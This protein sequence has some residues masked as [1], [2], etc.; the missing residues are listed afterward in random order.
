MIF[1]SN[2]SSTEKYHNTIYYDTLEKQVYNYIISCG[3]IPE[4]DVKVVS[5]DK[6]LFIKLNH[7]A[8][9]FGKKNSLE[10]PFSYHEYDSGFPCYSHKGYDKFKITFLPN[11]DM[12]KK[13]DAILKKI[14]H[15]NDILDKY[16]EFYNSIKLSEKQMSK[17]ILDFLSTPFKGTKWEV[18][19]W[20][21]FDG[22]AAEFKW[23]T[24][25]EYG[26]RF[27]FYVKRKPD[28]PADGMYFRYNN[29]TDKLIVDELKVERY[30]GHNYSKDIVGQKEKLKDLEFFENYK[31][32][33]SF[34][35][36]DAYQKFKEYCVQA[37]EILSQL[38]K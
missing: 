35:G 32:T 5:T 9:N 7:Y 6:E 3:I 34:E 16:L 30:D 37:T 29:D 2:I 8:C 17:E 25:K 14:K 12:S 15:N 4:N 33:F 27:G 38:Q 26:S 11:K 19:F 1:N 10:F 31:N 21:L 22:F 24:Y 23:D 13:F 20:K 18:G 36:C 28:A